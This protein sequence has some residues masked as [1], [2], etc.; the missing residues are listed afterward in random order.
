MKWFVRHSLRWRLIRSKRLFA[1][2]A[3]PKAPGG[4]NRNS[5]S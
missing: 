4:T 2:A 3:A 5:C 1:L